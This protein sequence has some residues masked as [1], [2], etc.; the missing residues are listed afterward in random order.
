MARARLRWAI[1]LG[2]FGVSGATGLVLEV[3]WVRMLTQVFGSSNL[4]IATVLGT[5]MAGLGAGS[6]LGGKI[7]DRLRR[8]PL[9]AYAACELGVAASAALVPLVVLGLPGANAWL[10]GA[11]GDAPLLLASARFG[12][13]ALL[14][15]VPTVF[16]GATLPIL[17]RAAVTSD[18]ELPEL[19][20]RVAALYAIN[21]A[22]AVTGAFAGGIVLLPA[23]GTRTVGALA[24]AAALGVAVVAASLA[25]R[26]R[27][28]A[29]VRIDDAGPPAAAASRRDHID[30]WIAVGAFALSGGLAMV[31]QVLL[32]RA[33]ALVLGSAIQSF[34]LVLVVF[35][36]GISAGAGILG[37]RASRS[38]DPLGWLGAT[39]AGVGAAALL[40]LWALPSL[41]EL[42]FDLVQASG[43]GLDSLAG[44]GVRALVVAVIA[45]VTFF[46]GA[47]M[48]LAVRAYARSSRSV[49]ADVGF[50]YMLNTAGAVIGSIAGGF[51]VL[52]LAGLGGG[53]LGCGVIALVAALVVGLRARTRALDWGTRIAVAAAVMLA[54]AASG[55]DVTALSWGQYQNLGAGEYQRG[56]RDHEL[57]FYR[58]GRA[59]TVTVIRH[60]SGAVSLLNNGKP[61]GS[62]YPSDTRMQ[63]MLGLLPALLHEGERARALVIGYGTGITAGALTR[64][65]HVDSVDTVELE[66]AVYEAADRHFA[67]FNHDAHRDPTVRRFVGDGRNFLAA[68]GGAYDIIVSEPPNP[69]VA[70]VANLFSHELYQTAADHLAPGGVFC[71]WVQLYT[72]RPETVRKM[73]RTFHATFPN[74]VVFRINPFETILIGTRRR[75]AFDERRLAARMAVPETRSEL[76]RARVFSP[77]QLFDMI[78]LTPPELAAYAGDGPI[79]TD[80]NGRLEFDAQR[81][82]LHAVS[83]EANRRALFEAWNRELA[84]YGD[85]ET[86]RE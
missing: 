45:P 2:C 65:P 21:T 47:M 51:A 71:Q 62:S 35:L 61:D 26:G 49:G 54:F 33:M 57:L 8:D 76:A 84:G 32:S 13:C 31:M 14:L 48:P 15:I 56:G 43:A 27:G 42:Y 16:M 64:A 6:W 78:V 81:D 75:L 18:S 34:T 12:L 5:F 70:G 23:L 10:W 1:V 19:G 55:A 36:V 46:L 29:P 82:Y 74:V 53:L 77:A 39:L 22:G 44:I 73:Y 41:P 50:A 38:V 40:V 60:E 28:R 58:D 25:R 52:P 83:S 20:R 86:L 85:L 11:L 37:R 80:D 3:V 72:I 30:G 69:W 7:A 59:S 9:W 66:A 24:I 4:A 67:R 17:S 63:I 79:Y 68:R